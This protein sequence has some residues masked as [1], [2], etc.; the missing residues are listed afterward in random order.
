MKTLV[1]TYCVEF[2]L[3]FQPIQQKYQRE[4]LSFHSVFAMKSPW[5]L[6]LVRLRYEYSISKCN[7]YNDPNPL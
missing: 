5:L 1:R 2:R 6:A 7:L 4:L 3:L